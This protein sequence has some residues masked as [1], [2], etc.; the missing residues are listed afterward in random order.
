VSK[1]SLILEFE[2]LEFRSLSEIWC[3]SLSYLW[4][5]EMSLFPP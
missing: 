3:D 2:A 5:T 1:F 4:Q